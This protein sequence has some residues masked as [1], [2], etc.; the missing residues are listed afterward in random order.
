MERRS[1]I[2]SLIAACLFCAGPATAA[3]WEYAGNGP[4]Y[5]AYLGPRNLAC[6]TGSQQS[7]ID[8]SGDVSAKL[9]KL[10]VKWTGRGGTMVNNGHTVQINMPS[11]STLTRDGEV[12]DLV[13]FHF[14]TPSEHRVKGKTFPMEVHFV[15][16]NDKTDS[17]GVLAVFLT[18]GAKKEGFAELAAGFPDKQGVD[19]D[20]K[21]VDP[22]GLLPHSLD[23][24]LYEGSL[25]TPPCSEDVDWMIVKE[26]LEVSAD[27]IAKF[28]A[29]YNNNARPIMLPHRRFILSSD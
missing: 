14:H 8:I 19:V 7:P 25:T 11:G 28:T 4:D 18:V 5:W 24:W 9:S 6:I 10:A 20:V 23:Y 27:D 22:N 16:K 12:Y 13:Q 26:P 3:P 1:F 2:K 17:Y 15:H 29:I 21:H